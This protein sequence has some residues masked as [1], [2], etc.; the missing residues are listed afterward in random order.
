MVL[1]L[2]KLSRR[3][4]PPCLPPR[5]PRRHTGLLGGRCAIITLAGTVS[6]FCGSGVGGGHSCHTREQGPAQPAA[7]VAAAGAKRQ[8]PAPGEPRASRTPTGPGLRDLKA[9]AGIRAQRSCPG[10][11]DP[12]L[13]GSLPS[14]PRPRGSAASWNGRAAGWGLLRR[15]FPTARSPP[16]PRTPSHLSK[17]QG[18]RAVKLQFANRRQIHRTQAAAAGGFR[19]DLAV[20]HR[21]AVSPGGAAL[22]PSTGPSVPVLP[23]TRA[24]PTSTHH[25][26]SLHFS[27]LNHRL[28]LHFAPSLNPTSGPEKSNLIHCLTDD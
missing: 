1:D 3:R 18:P 9:G 20:V 5:G 15:P 6:L 28:L 14:P 13:R 2:A 25:H 16:S 27:R 17:A 10:L 21:V 8:A 24:S 11:G 19:W 26:V 23:A 22:I 7:A 4:C 12:A